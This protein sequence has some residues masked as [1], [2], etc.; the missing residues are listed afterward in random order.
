MQKNV[1]LFTINFTY[2]SEIM[3]KPISFACWILHVVLFFHINKDT[4]RRER[5]QKIKV[6]VSEKLKTIKKTISLSFGEVKYISIQEVI[7]Q[8]YGRKCNW[9][10]KRKY[11]NYASLE[12]RKVLW[13]YF[14]LSICHC[15]LHHFFLKHSLFCSINMQWAFGLTVNFYSNVLQ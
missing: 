13:H 5:K 15:V 9:E 14:C 1:V 10:K 6:T 12:T 11:L 8:I 3:Q 2:Y 7:E 4:R